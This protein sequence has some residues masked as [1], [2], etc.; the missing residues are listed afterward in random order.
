M[1]WPHSNLHLGFFL[2]L[3]QYILHCCFLLHLR[4]ILFGIVLLLTQ[5]KVKNT[6]IVVFIATGWLFGGDFPLHCIFK[7]KILP[8]N[9]K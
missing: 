2:S 5:R 4:N 9:G 3:A 1:A 7:E 8:A 6:K